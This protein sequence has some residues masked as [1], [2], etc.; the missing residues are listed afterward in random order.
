M[1][2]TAASDLRRLGLADA[3]LALEQQR[4]REAKAEVHR[5][6][7]ALVDEVVDG[8]EALGECLDVGYEVADLARR[9]TRRFARAHAAPRTF[10]CIPAQQK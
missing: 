2:S 8:A 4:L 5:R 1:S 7:E 9:V 6:G 3:G 10:A